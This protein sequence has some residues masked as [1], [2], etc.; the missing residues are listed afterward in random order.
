MWVGL[1]GL[2]LPPG[3]GATSLLP[4][5]VLVSGASSPPCPEGREI[6]S[7]EL[8]E[9][10]DG[11]SARR[12]L[13]RGE[14]GLPSIPLGCP[15]GR[16]VCWEALGRCDPYKDG[17]V[18]LRSVLCARPFLQQAGWRFSLSPCRCGQEAGDRPSGRPLWALN[19]PLSYAP[20][21][22]G[23]FLHKMGTGNPVMDL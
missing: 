9:G 16:R 11:A 4:F 2:P 6:L 19:S 15:E 20:Q 10:K 3:T 17:C 23:L 8:Q 12:N 5:A 1:Q 21:T 18:W 13:E 14:E 22:M 7:Q